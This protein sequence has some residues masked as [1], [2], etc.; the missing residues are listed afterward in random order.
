MQTSS[1]IK[2]IIIPL[3]IWLSYLFLLLL[4]FSESRNLDTS[5]YRSLTLVLIQA[6]VFYINFY[7]LLPAF[8]EKKRYLL[9]ILSLIVLVILSV[10]VLDELIHLLMSDEIRSYIRDGKGGINRRGPP[11]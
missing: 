11:R 2:S 5:L 4:F 8:F 6:I 9:Y 1:L 10:W 3:A 7:L